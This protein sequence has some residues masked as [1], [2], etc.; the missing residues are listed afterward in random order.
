MKIIYKCLI[1]ILCTQ[2]YFLDV[3]GCGN[4]S[5]KIR[6]Y[7]YD[8]ENYHLELDKK[9]G[10]YFNLREEG[11]KYNTLDG[12]TLVGWGY[13]P[14]NHKDEINN[15]NDLESSED[16]LIFK[17]LPYPNLDD[18]AFYPILIKTEELEEFYNTSKL[19]KVTIELIQEF[20]NSF[21]T[22]TETIMIES[23]LNKSVLTELTSYLEVSGYTLKCLTE[24]YNKYQEFIQKNNND[25]DINN[26]I[27][28]EEVT[29]RDAL[30]DTYSRFYTATLT[31]Y[32]YYE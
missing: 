17:E 7:S 14:Y 5:K 13:L 11:E 6:F 9:L 8:G 1:L 25:I 28:K 26:Y 10:R 19:A 29:V 30:N 3:I 23:S 21:G 20:N 12:H 4:T 31:I 22:Y 27:L 32:A 18:L 16:L 2:F 24:S 15:I